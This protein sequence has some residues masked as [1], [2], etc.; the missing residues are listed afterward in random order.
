[1]PHPTAGEMDALQGA[2]ERAHEQEFD[3]AKEIAE[4]ELEAIEEAREC[5]YEEKLK[6]AL[7][8][9]DAAFARVYAPGDQNV[10]WSDFMWMQPLPLRWKR[11][12]LLSRPVK[13]HCGGSKMR[14]RAWL[15]GK[16]LTLSLTNLA[17][18]IKL[19]PTSKG[20]RRH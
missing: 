7:L 13:K 3:A 10:A 5:A 17:E 20:K 14:N 4:S 9:A 6:A 18:S 15:S 8:V 16:Q 19:S 1:M 12:N 11:E 2:D